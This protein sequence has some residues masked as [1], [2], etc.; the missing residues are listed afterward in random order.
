MGALIFENVW[1]SQTGLIVGNTVWSAALVVGAFMAGLA[2][3]NA[4]AAMLAWRWRNLVRSYGLLEVVAAVSAS[5]L[6]LIFPFLPTLFRPLMSPFLDDTAT[7]NLIRSGIAFALMVIPAAA[8][9]TT[10]PLL[11][12]PLEAATGSYGLA[13]G[14][15]YGVNTLGAVAGTLLAELVLIPAIGLRSS[16]LFAAVCNL[17]AAMFALRI[18]A[19][20]FFHQAVSR[21]RIPQLGA[22]SKRIVAAAF[23]AGAVF[24]A[25]EVIWFRFLVLYFSGTSLLFAVML[26]IVLT[27]IGLGGMLASRWLS[28]GYP[29]GPM[30]RLAAAGAAIGVVGGYTFLDPV[31]S[32]LSSVPELPKL[33]R[34]AGTSAFLMAP[35]GLLSGVLFTAL[36]DQLRTRIGDAA[37]TTGVLAL[38]NTLGSVAGS[39]VA[40]F[41]LLPTQGIE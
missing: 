18:A 3:G 1:F 41:V 25:L 33:A 11:S 36:G 19:H 34:M 9:G 15:L 12:K 7:L 22:D 13:L 5:A 27:G 40:A 6:V 31:W 29:S 38:A 21:F 8:L 2:L 30:A 32:A 17:T 35:V 26:A 20:P 14:R 23:I 16:G 39:L 28:R 4:L 10:L 37:A 24:L